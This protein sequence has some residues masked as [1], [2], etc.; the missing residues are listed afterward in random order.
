MKPGD[1]VLVSLPVRGAAPW[2]LRPALFL[3]DLPGAFQTVLLCGISTVL[4]NVASDWD[5]LIKSS[6]PDFASS[7]LHRPST[8]RLSYLFAVYPQQIQGKIGRVGDDR[9]DRL[10]GRLSAWLSPDPPSKSI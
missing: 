1:L 9:L 6:D 7:R 5:E 10:L 2:K 8:V 4:E 3:A